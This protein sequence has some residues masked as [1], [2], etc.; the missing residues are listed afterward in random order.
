[1][2]RRIRR[3]ELN[4]LAREWHFSLDET[5]LDEFHALTEYIA[6]VL[7]GLDRQSPA[8]VRVLEAVRDAGRRPAEG[9]DPYNAIVRFC[10]VKAD[11]EG[12]LSGV[13]LGLKDA[14]AIAG[15]PMTCGSRVL[16]GFV[17]TRDSVVTERLLR[18]GAEIVA[19]TN[20]DNLAFSGGGDTSAYGPTLCP[21]DTART[22]G[23]SSSGSGAALYYDDVDVTLGGDQG[24][25]I[26]VPAAWCAVLGLKPTHSLV[27]YTAIAG[28]DQSF[29]HC[30]PMA[31]TAADAARLLQAIAGKDESDPRQREVPVQDYLKAVAEAPDNLRGV[32]IGV[33]PEGFDEAVGIEQ[34]VAEATR[35]AIERLRELGAEV[36]ELSVPEHLQAGGIAFVGFVEGMTALVGAGGN[37]YHW[38]GAYWPELA[39]ALREGLAAFGDE[40]SPQMKLTLI[41]GSHLR[42][43]YRGALYAKA[44]NL[45]PALRAGYDRALGEV[46][47]L[48]MPTTPGLPHVD[49]PTLPISAHVKRGW[50][51]LANTYPMDM[52]GHPAL[53]IPAAEAGGLPAGVMLVG[54]HFDDAGLL[55]VAR[56]YEQRYGW[57]P[58]HPGDPRR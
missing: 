47:Y 39:L 20:M 22:A 57:V 6:D 28:I 7:D 14:I 23:G 9:E 50:G 58:A 1:M 52:T 30:G 32:R 26:R 42:Q 25:S 54:R 37:G 34:E 16:Q 17:P 44:Q 31:R 27:P 2:L 15:I 56:T 3:S 48:V 36:C 5:E 38:T 46:D 24:G 33:V 13:R 11:A 45:R 53:T 19:T 29:D 12:I 21:F 8:P 51:V 18:A 4:E 49:D 10:S 40:L 43:R 55:A 41:C 35:G